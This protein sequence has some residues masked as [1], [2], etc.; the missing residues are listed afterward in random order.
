M[1]CHLLSPLQ[2]LTHPDRLLCTGEQASAQ[3]PSR[4]Q[5]HTGLA[6]GAPEGS[7]VSEYP[8]HAAQKE[9]KPF[10]GALRVGADT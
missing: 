8:E 9:R 3:R 1:G 7:G 2:D 10:Q 4:L 5:A 6:K